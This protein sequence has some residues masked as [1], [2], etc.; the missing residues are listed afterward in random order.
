MVIPRDRKAEIRLMT[1]TSAEFFRQIDQLGGERIPI[2][3]ANENRFAIFP[4]AGTSPEDF[5]DLCGKLGK[6][7]LTPSDLPTDQ[8]L[9]KGI[10]LPESL[11]QVPGKAAPLVIRF[12]SPGRSMSMDRK[13]IGLHLGA[14]YDICI[15][16]PRGT[17]DSSGTPSEG[18]YYLDAEAVFE[19]ALKRSYTADRIWVSGYCEGAAV[20]AHLKKKYHAEG[21]NFIAEN[22]FNSLLDTMKEHNFLGRCFGDRAL[23]EI[24]STDPAIQRLVEQ[25]G[26]DTAA[27]FRTLS[28]SPGK[29]LVIHTDNDKTMPKESIPKI[30]QAI[31]Q[32]GPYFEILRHHPNPRANG[33]MQPPTEDPAIWRQYV[34]IVV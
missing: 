3:L 13:F 10:L 30:R 20:G 11:Q 21:V 23:P 6:F 22:P 28:A 4:K 32:A 34:Q 25:D 24:H 15:S 12:H 33:H 18:G 5:Q 2:R 17:V 29:C 26:F 16:D 27:K 7:Y 1:F 19:H 14:G 9:R 8:G 31:S